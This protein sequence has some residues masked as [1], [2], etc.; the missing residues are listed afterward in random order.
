M[1]KEIIHM[2]A[3]QCPEEEDERFNKWYDEVH[4]PMLI[5]CKTLKEVKRYKIVEEI[6]GIANYL[7]EYRFDSWEDFKTYSESPELSEARKEILQSWGDD[8]PVKWRA[9]YRIIKKWKKE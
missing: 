2:V 1:Q 4:I 6:E 9:Q 3:V 8:F 7:T 5:K